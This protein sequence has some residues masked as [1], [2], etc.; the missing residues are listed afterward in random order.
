MGESLQ[1]SPT[2]VPV[3]VMQVLSHRQ[4]FSP[5]NAAAAVSMLGSTT[6]A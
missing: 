5:V 2:E 3:Q 4:S 1:S 6:T